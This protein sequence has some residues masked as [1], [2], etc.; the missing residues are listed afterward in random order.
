MHALSRSRPIE[1]ENDRKACYNS[2]S[3]SGNDRHSCCRFVKCVCLSELRKLPI[4]SI[5]RSVIQNTGRR[6]GD[7]YIKNNVGHQ[8]DK[9]LTF[10]CLISILYPCECYYF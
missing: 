7:I 10:L 5:Q 8:S 4:M 1:S 3:E 9:T 6:G 2:T